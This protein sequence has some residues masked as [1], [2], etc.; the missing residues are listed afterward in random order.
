VHHPSHYQLPY[1]PTAH[2]KP[3][4]EWRN[5]KARRLQMTHHDELMKKANA[6]FATIKERDALYFDARKFAEMTPSEQAELM[7]Y[8]RAVETAYKII[9]AIPNCDLTVAIALLTS[10]GG[11]KQYRAVN[12]EAEVFYQERKEREEM[13]ERWREENADD[14]LL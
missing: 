1:L 4:D 11:W 13:M 3:T 12:R 10:L 14:L 8:C 6:V 9:P 2:A 5:I 7:E